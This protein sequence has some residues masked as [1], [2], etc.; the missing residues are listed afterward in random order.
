MPTNGWDEVDEASY[1]SFPASDPPAWGSSHAVAYEVTIVPEDTG[2]APARRW[3]RWALL[4][5]GALAAIGGTVLI[6][7]WLR[8]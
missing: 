7:R 2:A 1:E 4:G 6:V 8:A 3:R 5:A